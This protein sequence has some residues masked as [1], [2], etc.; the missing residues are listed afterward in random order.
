MGGLQA[1]YAPAMYIGLSSRLDGFERAALTRALERRSV[2]Q[3]TLMRSTIHLVT[4]RDY[5]ALALAVERPRRA[6]WLKVN[7]D[8]LGARDMSAAAR[9]LRRRLGGT[10]LR[11]TEIE[12]LVGKR[13]A[14]GVGHWLP[15]VRVPPSSPRW[16]PRWSACACA[17][18]PPRTARSS[19]TCPAR[20]CRTPTRRRP[21]GCWGRGTRSCWPTRAAPRSS[22]SAIARACSTCACRSRCRPSWSTARWRARGATR[23]AASPCTR[24]SAWTARRCARCAWRASGWRRCTPDRPRPRTIRRCATCNG[25]TEGRESLPPWRVERRSCPVL[26]GK[27]DVR[28]P[29]PARFHPRPGATGPPRAPRAPHRARRPRRRTCRAGGAGPARSAA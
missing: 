14:A 1:Q 4:A 7:R 15:M 17:A 27:T 10:T 26:G 16:R 29:P 20:R 19:S 5:W 22:P 3:G 6:W 12:E 23:T 11:R 8:G 13:P 18:S 2:V 25:I 28:R 21:S 24:S 9:R